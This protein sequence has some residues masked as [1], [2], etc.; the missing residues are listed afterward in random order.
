MLNLSHKDTQGIRVKISKMFIRG[1]KLG[2]IQQPSQIIFLSERS[3]QCVMR[4]TI[5]LRFI[6][7]AA[8]RLALSGQTL[9]GC[10]VDDLWQNSRPP[11]LKDE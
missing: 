5:R 4:G 3:Y 8:A 2:I 6:L 11:R 9:G 7:L 1:E 10:K